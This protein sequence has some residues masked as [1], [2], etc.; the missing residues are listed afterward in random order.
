MKNKLDDKG[1]ELVDERVFTI[2]LNGEEVEFYIKQPS[3]K[4][5]EDAEAAYADKYNR[6][7]AA[8]SMFRSTLHDKMKSQGLWTDQDE[9]EYTSLEQDIK[10]KT[11][12]LLKGNIKLETARKYAL[13]I[14]KM[15]ARMREMKQDFAANDSTTV[16]G[17]ASNARFHYLLVACLV[18]NND[19]NKRYFDSVDAYLSSENDPV[20][21][22]GA[23]KF[24][25]FNYGLGMGEE[26]LPENQFLKQFNFIDD[27]LR[28]VDE[29]GKLIDLE[30]RHIDELGRYIKYIKDE[31]GNETTIFIDINGREVDE[32]GKYKFD[33]IKYL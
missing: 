1:K 19:R 21:T 3:V 23:I 9:A 10:A 7:V 8:G 12:S 16:E 4:E 11:E 27:S 17:Q 6:A 24:A 26:D 22:V 18:Y 32:N 14:R 25:Y 30:G 5:L 2:E 29:N 31:E 15:R 33:K 13:E 28:L 20:A